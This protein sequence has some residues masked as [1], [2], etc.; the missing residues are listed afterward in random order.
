MC[1]ICGIFSV[2]ADPGHLEST[3]GSMAK[4]LH[5]RGPDAQACWA[6]GPGIAFG[7]ARLAIMELSDKGAQPMHSSSGRFTICFN[8]EIYNHQYLQSRLRNN[9]RT[10]RGE[11]D[12]EALIESIDCFGIDWTLRNITGMFAFGL[13]DAH[14]E[15][16]TLAR[17]RLGEKPLY[18]GMVDGCLVFGSEL[19]VFCEHPKFSRRINQKALAAFLK[20]SYV[21][22]PLCIYEDVKKMPAAHYTVGCDALDFFQSAPVAYWSIRNSEIEV[23]NKTGLEARLREIVQNQMISDVP[24]GCFLS[25]GIDSSLVTAIA[26]TQCDQPINSF[27]IGFHSDR[28]DESKHAEAVAKKLGTNHTCWAISEPDILN[29]VP[30]LSDVYDEPFADSSQLPS[31]LLA[32]MTRNDVT[33][34]LSGDGGDELFC[35]Y[36]RYIWGNKLHKVLRRLP[37]PFRLAMSR[38]FKSRSISEWNNF[39]SKYGQ[40]LPLSVS[41]FGDKAHKM[42]HLVS[43]NS[44]EQ[45]HDFLLSSNSNSENVLLNP[46]HYSIASQ[47]VDTD[48]NFTEEMM[49][50]DAE[51]YLS[52][53]IMV[54][55]DR[56]TMFAS[57]ESRAPFLDHTLFEYARALPLDQK[58]VSGVPKYPLRT[59]LTKFIPEQLID[60]PKMGFSLPIGAWLRT[61]LREWAEDLLT[62]Q[63]LEN[64]GFFDSAVIRQIWQDHL[65]ERADHENLLWNILVFQHWYSR[66]IGF[67][68]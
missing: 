35:G 20:Y 47:N 4:V 44:R 18:Y 53:D 10:L 65:E 29:I 26:Q 16:L 25:G 28:Y 61:D 5:H 15:Q 54:K 2:G 14:L 33:V 30:C 64:S 34:C 21:P 41:H 24:V 12:T 38:F 11:S 43:A 13:W 9:G 46:N 55:V 31:I 58:L 66:W 39:H 48:T 19:K 37:L 8:G 7:H 68:S 57:L 27:T 36:E 23:N 3:V 45:F 63:K 50:N 62:C 1:G 40:L 60:R 49:L 56:A 6:A 59:L 67:S 42:A 32:Q 17:D 52:D 22:T 51:F